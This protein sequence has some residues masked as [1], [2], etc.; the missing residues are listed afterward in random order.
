MGLGPRFANM[1]DPA[2]NTDGGEPELG[3][4]SSLFERFRTAVEHY[5]QGGPCTLY[6]GANARLDDGG[7][8]QG[9]TLDLPAFVTL[10]LA[11]GARLSLDPK[12]SLIIRGPTDLGLWPRFEL[13]AGA[14]VRLLGPLEGIRPE[15]WMSST[16]EPADAVERAVGAA[17]HRI[18]AG[19][20]AV[21]VLLHGPYRLGR[22]VWIAPRPAGQ[23]IGLAFRGR[24]PVGDT[25][26]EATFCR[27]GRFPAHW[28]LL[29][30]GAGVR[31]QMTH[32]GF[33]ARFEQDQL[34]TLD[35]GVVLH[36]GL[37]DGTTYDRCT[38]VSDGTSALRV[39]PRA[40]DGEAGG[41]AALSLSRCWVHCIAGARWAT[42][43]LRVDDAGP[44]ALRLD[45]CTFRGDAYAFV[46]LADGSLEATGCD[47]ANQAPLVYRSFDLWPFKDQTGVIVPDGT[48]TDFALGL[49][50]DPSPDAKPPERPVRVNVALTHHRSASRQMVVASF[51]DRT[52]CGPIVVNNAVHRPPTDPFDSI[53]ASIVCRGPLSAAGIVLVGCDLGAKVDLGG[54]SP[55]ARLVN[56]GSWIPTVVPSDAEV[57]LAGERL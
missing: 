38:F 19:V 29:R 36:D 52:H 17:L 35:E 26:V 27:S 33:D 40:S 8:G 43:V 39:T 31:T 12:V 28:A 10:R 22:T 54:A 25:D 57:V 5:R 45:G 21:P 30:V 48:Q 4:I 24:H 49:A 6:L 41:A 13:A 14:E 51:R 9:A 53:G 34:I 46:G 15:W 2:A 3:A 20:V 11:P 44:L 18:E 1:L 42:V 16:D 50:A 32:V 47:M 7:T 37:V 23:E 56:A 55:G